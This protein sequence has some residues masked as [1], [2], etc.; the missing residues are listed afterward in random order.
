MSS[1]GLL[2][3]LDGPPAPGSGIHVRVETPFGEVESQGCIAW[4]QREVDQ[5][6]AGIALTQLHSLGDRLRWERLIGQLAAQGADA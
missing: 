2:L 4:I 6:K 5:E 1:A 3:V